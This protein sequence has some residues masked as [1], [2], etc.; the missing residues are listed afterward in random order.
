MRLCRAFWTLSRSQLSIRR[1]ERALIG[2]GGNLGNVAANMHAAL[3]LIDADARRVAEELRTA[4]GVIRQAN[5]DLARE[6]ERW[7]LAPA[8]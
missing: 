1:T 4:M 8:R 5:H 3:A 7:R 2:L 6:I